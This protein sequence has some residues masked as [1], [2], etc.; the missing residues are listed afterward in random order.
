VRPDRIWDEE[1]PTG[2]AEPLSF[3]QFFHAMRIVPWIGNRQVRQYGPRFDQPV[4]INYDLLHEDL[5]FETSC[6]FFGGWE[7]VKPVVPAFR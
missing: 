3:S 5:F 4:P 1:S 2:S 7:M 6:E